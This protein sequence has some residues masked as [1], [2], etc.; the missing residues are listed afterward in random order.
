MVISY[1]GASTWV[2]ND[3]D[4]RFNML[5]D[6]LGLPWDIADPFIVPMYDSIVMPSVNAVTLMKG[7]SWPGI[8]TSMNGMGLCHK[9]PT[10]KVDAASGNPLEKRFMLKV[11]VM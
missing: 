2:V 11:D 6:S 3:R 10:M 8:E 5:E 7:N 4:V 9:A 1:S